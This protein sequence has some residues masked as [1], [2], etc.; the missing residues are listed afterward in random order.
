MTNGATGLASLGLF[1]Y[2]Q[3]LISSCH[4]VYNH[5][6]FGEEDVLSTFSTRREFKDAENEWDNNTEFSCQ[7][8]EFGI[9]LILQSEKTNSS[10]I[11]SY[12]GFSEIRYNCCFKRT[13]KTPTEKFYSSKVAEPQPVTLIKIIFLYRCF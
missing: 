12:D 3:P 11:T 13:S 6:F 8:C 10:N 4:Q 2:R 1:A 9:F 7:N 5:S